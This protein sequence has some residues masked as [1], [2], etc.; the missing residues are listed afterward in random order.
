MA[1]ENVDKFVSITIVCDVCG[2]WEAFA[3]N[4]DHGETPH[5]FVDEGSS[6][7][8]IIE[9]IISMHRPLGWKTYYTS[10]GLH[11][12]CGKCWKARTGEN[13]YD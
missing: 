9:A 3:A 8:I 12:V 6:A 13:P 1:L 5:P 4:L 2:D 10:R 11:L 7:R